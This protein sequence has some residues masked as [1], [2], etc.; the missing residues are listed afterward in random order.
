MVNFVRILIFRV[1]N[2]LVKP[3]MREK[4]VK[5]LLHCLLYSVR[6]KGTPLQCYD[7]FSVEFVSKC[8]LL[9]VRKRNDF[10]KNSMDFHVQV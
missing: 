2:F 4:L 1:R 7:I 9:F 6:R 8:S 5:N 3:F 10:C